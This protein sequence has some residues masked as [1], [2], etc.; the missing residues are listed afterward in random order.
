MTNK[1]GGAFQTPAGV[2]ALTAGF[3]FLVLGFPF[4]YLI[5][6]PSPYHTIVTVIITT[7]GVF[8]GVFVSNKVYPRNK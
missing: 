1:R 7:L 8:T 3:V 5:D 6:L 4:F 2:S